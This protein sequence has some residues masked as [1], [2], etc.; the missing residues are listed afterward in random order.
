MGEFGSNS[1]AEFWTLFRRAWDEGSGRG[2]LV[3]KRIAFERERGGARQR[4]HHL[5]VA[6]GGVE[7]LD[8]PLEVVPAVV[9]ACVEA[10]AQQVIKTIYVKL[11]RNE[12]PDK[13]RQIFVFDSRNYFVRER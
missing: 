10:V 8:D 1:V 9:D 7:V 6:L 13:R 3:K 4:E 12:L 2:G 5:P 11:R